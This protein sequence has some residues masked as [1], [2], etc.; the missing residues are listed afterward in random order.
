MSHGTQISE[1]EVWVMADG[2]RE[3]W[4]VGTDEPIVFIVYVTTVGH[5]TSQSTSGV[6]S[7]RLLLNKRECAT[8]SLPGVPTIG[9]S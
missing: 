6:R 4:P 1:V 3:H 5:S 9:V 7:H 8:A 2:E